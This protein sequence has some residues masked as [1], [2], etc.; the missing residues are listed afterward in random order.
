M[1][2]TLRETSAVGNPENPDG[3]TSGRGIFLLSQRW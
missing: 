2:G 1:Q 3:G